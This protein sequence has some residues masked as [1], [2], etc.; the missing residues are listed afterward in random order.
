MRESQPGPLAGRQPSSRP[1]LEMAEAERARGSPGS[2]SGTPSLADD[3]EA[4]LD[5]RGL[6][7]GKPSSIAPSLP[8]PEAASLAGQTIGALH[9]RLPHRPGRH[10]QRLARAPQRR[11]IR[12][13]SRRQ[14]AQ[15]EP[16]RPRRRGA[17]PARGQHPRAPGAPPHRAACSTPGSRRPASRTSFSSTSKA[18]RST[19]ICDERPP[20]RRGRLRL[21]LDVLEAVAHAHANL[22]VHRDIKPSNVLV[23]EDGQVKLVDFGIA[24]L[25]EGEG[26]GGADDGAH[27]RGRAARSLPSSRRP[28]S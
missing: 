20:R 12:G 28:S 17:V 24:K 18:S 4:L 10:G 21:F 16:R 13:Q 15:R 9:A 7:A 26:E 2:G 6:P 1:A 8:R 14:A 23:D 11:P 22:I 3:I 25:L 19:A 5:E 27:A